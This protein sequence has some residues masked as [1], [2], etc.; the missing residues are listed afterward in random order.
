MEYHFFKIK[1]RNGKE[2]QFILIYVFKKYKD[3]HILHNFA[4]DVQ[5]HIMHNFLSIHKIKVV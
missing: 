3:R 5:K 2:K 4:S 1:I